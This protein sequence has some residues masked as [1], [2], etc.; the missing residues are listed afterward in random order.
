MAR[1]NYKKLA[2]ENKKAFSALLKMPGAIAVKKKPVKKSKMGANNVFNNMKQTAFLPKSKYAVVT[3]NTRQPTGLTTGAATAA[4]GYIYTLNG[5]WKVNPSD[6]TTHK[7]MGFDTAM[8][9]Y[10]HYTVA[11]VKA[12]VRFYN[13]STYPIAIGAYLSPDATILTDPTQI[14][15]NGLTK[16]KWI[17]NTSGGGVTSVNMYCDIAKFMGKKIM[18]EDDYR[19]SSIANPIEQ[20]YLCVY[21]YSPDGNAGNTTVPFEI[22]FKFYSK[23]SEPRKQVVN[24]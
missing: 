12:T 7:P 9:Y 1:T 10:E 23:F 22:E 19:G 16:Q 15:E 18:N 3:F 21:A 11:K 5:L 2:A 8:A 20:V 24:L 14:N 17:G 13:K 4:G 6:A